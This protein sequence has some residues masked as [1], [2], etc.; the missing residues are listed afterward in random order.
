MRRPDRVSHQLPHPSF[1]PTQ[2]TMRSPLAVHPLSRC[3]ASETAEPRPVSV[4]VVSR[5][6]FVRQGRND[7]GPVETVSRDGYTA[8]IIPTG[9]RPARAAPTGECSRALDHPRRRLD[10]AP[11]DAP[12]PRRKDRCPCPLL[13]SISA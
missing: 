1:I 13:P 8:S 12:V 10:G 9:S 11:V 7:V 5:P 2:E 6:R 4:A 3:T